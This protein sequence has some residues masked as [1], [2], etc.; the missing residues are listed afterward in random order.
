MRVSKDEAAAWFET[1]F[2]VEALLTMRRGKRCMVLEALYATGA[3]AAGSNT[4]S[5]L[6]F[7]VCALN[8]LT[9]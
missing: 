4:A 1:R 8:G 2:L 6:D 9:I 7:K 3:S 5:I